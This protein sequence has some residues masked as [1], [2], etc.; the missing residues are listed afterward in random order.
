MNKHTTDVWTI[1]LFPSRS[2][3]AI[4]IPSIVVLALTTVPFTR[5]CWTHFLLIMGGLTMG[6]LTTLGLVFISLCSICTHPTTANACKSVF[7]QRVNLSGHTLPRSCMWNQWSHPALWLTPLYPFTT[8]HPWLFLHQ[9]LP[10]ANNDFTP[11]HPNHTNCIVL[12]F[13]ICRHTTCIPCS[14]LPV[15][16]R[17]VC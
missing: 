10:I 3:R 12:H 5:T 8:D 15:A 13:F 11:P 16:R 1:T 4:T 2:I 14:L 17:T 6:E 7:T 9:H